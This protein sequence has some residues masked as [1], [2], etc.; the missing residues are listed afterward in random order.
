MTQS[1]V[2]ERLAISQAAYCRLERGEIEFAVSK[3]FDL[4][5]LYGVAA[6]VLMDGL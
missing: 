1:G 4:A 3:L 2:A 5:D 6:S